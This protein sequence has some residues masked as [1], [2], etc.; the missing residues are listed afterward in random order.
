[1]KEGLK[2][3]LLEKKEEFLM[4][5]YFITIELPQNKEYKNNDD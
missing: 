3:A 1:M 2:D 5:E 4:G